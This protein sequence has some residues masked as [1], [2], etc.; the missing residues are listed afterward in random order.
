MAISL[1]QYE[2]WRVYLLFII[3]MFGILFVCAPRFLVTTKPEVFH[4]SEESS[5]HCLKPSSGIYLIA[6]GMSMETTTHYSP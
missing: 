4:K 5:P 2:V 1:G 6:G 3:C